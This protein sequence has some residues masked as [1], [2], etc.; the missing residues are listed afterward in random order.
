[1]VKNADKEIIF[2]IIWDR[3]FWT[4]LTLGT[5]NVDFKDL[6]DQNEHEFDAVV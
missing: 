5:V 2:N 3:P 4:A 6:N 1:M